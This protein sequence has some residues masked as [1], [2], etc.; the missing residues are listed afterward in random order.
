MQV[1][2]EPFIQPI[3]EPSGHLFGY[4]ALMR[5]KGQDEL[6]AKLIPQWEKSGFIA[7]VDVAMLRYLVAFMRK[8]KNKYRL[9]VNISIRSIEQAGGECFDALLQ[10]RQEVRSVTVELTET[11]IVTDS[12][13]L[14]KFIA[15][16]QTNFIAIALDDC[17]PDNAFGT[18][19]FINLVRPQF[20]KIDGV[21]LHES[22]K[23]GDHTKIKEIIWSAKHSNSRVIAEFI[24]SKNIRS[25]AVNLRADYLQGFMIGMPK[26]IHNLLDQQHTANDAL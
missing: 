8:V 16:C 14:L 2:L 13:A 1:I 26:N 11:A 23:T 15:R 6:N 3:I 18:D 12:A 22:F 20:V 10:L 5:F 24:D 25:F 21:F 4:E 17:R 7:T 9:C 19:R